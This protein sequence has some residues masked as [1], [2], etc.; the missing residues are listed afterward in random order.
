MPL[1]H[2]EVEA[3]VAGILSE[4]LGFDVDA[5]KPPMNI[6]TDLGADSLDVIELVLAIEE[7]FGVE[8]ADEDGEKL[9]TV[10]D[11]VEYLAS[12]IGRESEA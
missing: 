1:T 6:V 2:E 3:K 7:E 9:V 10:G 12:R 5:I 4:Q 11:V 8:I